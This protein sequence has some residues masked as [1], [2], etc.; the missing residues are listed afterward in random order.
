M[1]RR[2]SL[3]IIRLTDFAQ[4]EALYRIRLKKDFDRRELRPLASLRRSWEHGAYDCYGLYDGGA[5][6]GYAFFV[7]LGKNALL[8]YLAIAEEHR[9]EGLGTVFLQMLASCLA[10]ADCAVCEVEDPERAQDEETRVQRERRLRFYLRSGYRKTELTSRVF[11][12]D[13]RILEAPT[14]KTHTADELRAVY[15]ALYKSILPGLFFHTQFRVFSE[16]ENRNE[17]SK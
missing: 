1:E 11:G 10:D 13:Y 15:T 17:V 4:V 2:E 12:V 6:L 5:L 9:D 7:R 3:S 8:D 16:S 14:G